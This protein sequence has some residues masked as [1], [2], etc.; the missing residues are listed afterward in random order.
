VTG[1]RIRSAWHY[2]W[3]DLTTPA[4]C[5]IPATSTSAL[6]SHISTKRRCTYCFASKYC[7]SLCFTGLIGCAVRSRLSLS[8]LCF[9]LFYSFTFKHSNNR[10]PIHCAV[11]GGSLELVKWM[12]ESHD[13]PLYVKKTKTGIPLSVQT[14][15]SRTL[16]DLAMTGRPKI[17]V[18][19]YLV[20]KNLSV[21][22]C[23]DQTLAPK[24]LQTLL[25]AGYQSGTT[26]SS[27]RDVVD[28]LA[29]LLSASS[30][31]SVA[32]IDDACI[33][34]CEKTMDCVLTPCGHQICCSDCGCRLNQCPV[35]KSECSL[36]RIRKV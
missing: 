33:I 35:C 13:V 8:H 2:C 11:M 9:S 31:E 3:V 10:F 21:M 16:I 32:S 36:V 34:C 27:M 6:L 28:D 4:P 29:S 26:L 15:K 7:D 25:R 24:T 5:T 1:C 22:D 30:H 14:S 17:D 19:G 18:L 12:V 20:S 23:K